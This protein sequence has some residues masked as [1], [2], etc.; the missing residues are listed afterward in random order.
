VGVTWWVQL[1][2]E[3]TAIASKGIGNTS[4]SATP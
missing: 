1:A 4:S 3:M 2:W